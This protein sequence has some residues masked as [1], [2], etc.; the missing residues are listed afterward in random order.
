LNQGNGNCD[1]P[2][3]NSLDVSALYA[4][5]SYQQLVLV[6]GK[7]DAIAT[8]LDTVHQDNVVLDTL[9]KNQVVAFNNQMQKSIAKQFDSLPPELVASPA[10]QKF[11][12]QIHDQVMAEV[13]AQIAS[14]KPSPK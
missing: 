4:A 2:W 3:F 7:L 9:L 8:K 14:A 11:A 12:Q 5:N 10:M 6:S 13:K 1:R